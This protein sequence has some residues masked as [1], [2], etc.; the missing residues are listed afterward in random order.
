MKTDLDP[1]TVVLNHVAELSTQIIKEKFNETPTEDLS[2]KPSQKSILG[3]KRI[4]IMQN[5]LHTTNVGIQ[6]ALRNLNKVQG[7]K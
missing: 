4:E 2:R 3:T 7:N 1:Q 5:G 6:K